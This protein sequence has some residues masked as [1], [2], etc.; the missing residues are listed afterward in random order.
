MKWQKSKDIVILEYC[1][2]FLCTENVTAIRVC[3]LSV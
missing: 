2:E 1:I 3:G